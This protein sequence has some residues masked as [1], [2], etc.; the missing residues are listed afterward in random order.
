MKV[1]I[2]NPKGTLIPE[3]VCSRRKGARQVIAAWYGCK[4]HEL[5]DKGYRVR[6]VL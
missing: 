5:W 3:T 4:W 6:R 1:G 2:F